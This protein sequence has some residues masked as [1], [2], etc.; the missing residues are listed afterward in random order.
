MTFKKIMSAVMAGAMVLSLGVTAFASA[1]P[2]TITLESADPFELPVTGTTEVPAIKITVPE[3]VGVI[4]N[5]YRLTVDATSIGG[6]AT[7]AGQIISP[8]QYIKNY[9]KVDVDASVKAAG[10]VTGEV[11]FA[12]ATVAAAE[13]TKKAYVNLKMG[14]CNGTAAPTTYSNTLAL[15]A[16]ETP[17]AV[18]STPL[19][20]LKSAD[21]TT[22]D[23]TGAI[24]F[25][26]EGDLST[27]P[28]VAWT[29]DDTFGATLFFEFT[30]KANAANP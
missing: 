28:E 3:T 20:M 1:A 2:G 26:F 14:T 17:V 16:T 5:P 15:T 10:Y 24:G 25:T 30:S 18:G 12:S 27:A 6:T 22:V 7:E 11:T 9:S 29:P 8:V 23:A 4:A 21:G 13:K 19:T